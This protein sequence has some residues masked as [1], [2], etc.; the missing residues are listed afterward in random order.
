MFPFASRAAGAQWPRPLTGWNTRR[1]AC[2]H[3]K[4]GA[5]AQSVVE[6]E[7][8]DLAP[9][10]PRTTRT[11]GW[12]TPRSGPLLT[13][14]CPA[15]RYNLFDS[16][17]SEKKR[18]RG[19]RRRSV[20]DESSPCWMRRWKKKKEKKKLNAPRRRKR[21]IRF[22]DEERVVESRSIVVRAATISKET[23]LAW[24]SFFL[25]LRSRFFSSNERRRNQQV[26]S[27]EGERVHSNALL[28]S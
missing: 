11:R 13:W 1:G 24:K 3:W 4:G 8:R 22:L 27:K 15:A 17:G 21:K 9:H 25:L 26:R 7:E 28:T 2:I 16:R 19:S 14:P 18:P 6:T 20:T 5:A 10:F 12:A 23:R